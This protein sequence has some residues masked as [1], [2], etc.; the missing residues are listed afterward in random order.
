MSTEI[1]TGNVGGGG[2]GIGGF[3][4][5]GSPNIFN[6]GTGSE[7][8][9]RSLLATQQA[10]TAW[11]AGY[12][13]DLDEENPSSVLIMFTEGG[14]PKAKYL[15]WSGPAQQWRELFTVIGLRGL[16]G[17][18][19]DT[20][21]VTSGVFVGN[22]LVFQN[23]D[24]S[25]AA[26]LNAK[27]DLRGPRGPRVNNASISGSDIN[28]TDELGGSFS[29]IGG[30]DALRGD[31]GFKFTKIEFVGNDAVFTYEDN[32]VVALIDAKTTLKGAKGDAAENVRYQFSI[33][34]SGPW[35]E[36]DE[37]VLNPDIYI[38]WR[39]SVDNGVTWSPNGIRF[40][41]SQAGLPNGYQWVEVGGGLA[42]RKGQNEFIQ[43][44]GEETYVKRLTVLNHILKF[45]TS[46]AVHDVSENVLFQNTITGRVYHPVWQ[47]ADVNDWAARVRRPLDSYTKQNF[48]VDG[49]VGP[50]T[51]TSV[52]SE[53]QITA[54]YN[55][56]V[57]S[58]YF[59]SPQRYTNVEFV[60]AQGGKTK[61][62]A[63]L[64][65]VEVGENKFTFPLLRD[66]LPFIDLIKDQIF[67]L[68]LKTSD[69]NLI[70][71]HPL[72]NDVTKPYWA[73]DFTMF[74]DVPVLDGRSA[75]AGF[76]FDEPT[77]KF[78][79]KTASNLEKGGVKV[80]TGLAILPDGTLYSTVSGS[81]VV[82]RQDEAGRLGLPQVAQAY[83][84][85]QVDAKR[86]FYLNPNENPAV[87]SNWIDGP[88][89]EAAVNGFKGA[90]DTAARTGVVEAEYGDYTGDMIPLTDK[91]TAKV[92]V[93][94]VDN[95]KPYLEEK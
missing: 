68:T 37:F 50:E 51:N 22:D 8:N 73:I 26:V 43:L 69:G 15:Q 77:A 9:A 95:G 81:L 87:L 66:G 63:P 7:A 41:A 59:S 19:G 11:L 57:Y 72:T 49:Y 79:L 10:N 64:P 52:P 75:G 17:D 67:D 34:T 91:T 20:A 31:R 28:F 1:V 85:I 61:V 30:A 35:V 86:V 33:G 6:A 4:L 56:R 36:S 39:W 27:I 71:L 40:Q 65:V 88:S 21:V 18:K 16:K 74:E 45:G 47:S 89:T 70:Q 2:S 42:L 23:S 80:G 46:K 14:V 82:V 32:S 93:L 83:T 5:G 94:I 90:K 62:I 13:A 54:Q 29:I 92:Y 48:V 76:T 78:N 44:D 24:G 55:L 84:C 60:I 3:K 25:T 38:Y 58:F 12:Q 53:L